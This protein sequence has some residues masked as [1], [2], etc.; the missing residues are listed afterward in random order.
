MRR[1]MKYPLAGLRPQSSQ[2]QSHDLLSGIKLLF[3]RARIHWLSEEHTVLQ[4][5]ARLE[6]RPGYAEFSARQQASR[7]R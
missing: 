3:A 6:I 7:L 1:E 4:D 5:G 2:T